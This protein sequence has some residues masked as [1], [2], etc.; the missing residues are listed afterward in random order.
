MRATL[1]TMRDLTLASRKDPA[2]KTLADSIVRTAPSGDFSAQNAAVFNWV[3][4]H[5]KYVRDI[6]DVETVSTPQRT[7]QARTGDCDDMAVLI[8]SLLEAIGNKT[9][10]VALGFN[11]GDYEHV[12]AQARMGPHWITLDPTVSYSF[13]GWHPPGETRR[14]VAHI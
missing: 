6:R 8:A 12:I 10:F 3:K 1:R 5:V 9:R 2:I 13:P 14:M 7:L 4:R 11:G